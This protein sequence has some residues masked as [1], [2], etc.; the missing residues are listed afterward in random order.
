MRKY[1]FTLIELLVVIAIIAILAAI[2]MPVFAQAREKAR[3]ASCQSNLKQIALAL[4]MYQQDYDGL[5]MSSAFL[6]RV[7][8]DAGAVCPDGLNIIRMLAGGTSW[9]LQPYIKNTQ[10]F[11]CPSDAGDNYWGR[12]S[13]WG[14]SSAPYWGVPSSYHFRHVFDVGGAGRHACRAPGSA[15]GMGGTVD[16]QL[17]QPASQ[18]VF[19]EVAAFH[20]EKHPL[21]GGVHPVSPSQVQTMRSINVAYADGHVKVFR[22]NYRFPNWN[23][24]HDLNWFTRDEAGNPC[25]S[26]PCTNATIHGDL[27]RGRD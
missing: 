20:N 12:S 25:D 17:G 5:M 23:P 24:N 2:L 13:N 21:F 19:Y 22:L 11:R 15:S 4:G 9:F 7:A 27:T 26:G 6:P 14:W 16:A 1:G 3:G 18:I 10:V 8:P